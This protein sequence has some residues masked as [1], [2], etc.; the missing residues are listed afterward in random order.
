MT[1]YLIAGIVTGG[2]YA[3]SALG[4]VFI[5]RSS[6]IFNFAQGAIGFF[7]AMVAAAVL[8]AIA[9]PTV[10]RFTGVGLELRAAVDNR[11]LA[12]SA[13][14]NAPAISAGSWAIGCALAGLAG[15]LLTPLAG[16]EPGHFTLLM[17]A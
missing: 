13:G 7:V 3:I 4:L 16:L 10:M 12:S 9:I 17:I 1:P 11:E 8:V 5:Y 6:K 14:I 2:V 15:V